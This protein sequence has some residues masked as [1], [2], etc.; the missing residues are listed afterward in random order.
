MTF[1]TAEI[2][3]QD[4]RPIG[5]YTLKWGNTIWRYTS[6]DRDV[7]R[8]ENAVEVTYTAIAVSDSGMVQGG[9]SQNDFTVD[10]PSNLPIRNL[11]SVNTPSDTIWLTVRRLHQGETDAPIYWIGVVMNV[12]GID[13]ASAQ[14]VG[15]PMT[16]TFKRTGLRL[17]WTRECPHF[18]YDFDCK[19]DPL[20]HEIIGEIDTLTATS[21]TLVDAIGEAD[22]HLRGGFISWEANADGTLERRMIESQVGQVVTLLGLTFGL[23]VG[24]TVK[25]YPGCDRS[26]EVCE[27][28]YD[29]LANH[30][31]F[32]FMPGESPFGVNL[33]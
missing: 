30:G 2:S 11:F 19:V 5:L 4:G 3:T 20:D 25:L 21:L 22:Q 28:K 6:A 17:C 33:F 23:E 12:K 29:N 13:E 10:I 31:G 26:P 24:Q 27:G 18:L 9:A 16:A 8:E 1:N 15:Q 32:K 14:I 7:T